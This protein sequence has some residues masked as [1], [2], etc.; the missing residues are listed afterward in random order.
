MIYNNISIK[1][2]RRCRNNSINIIIIV[3]VNFLN[4]RFFFQRIINRS[5]KKFREY[6]IIIREIILLINYFVNINYINK[7]FKIFIN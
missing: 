1:N 2:L 3:K 6:T 4:Y 7:R 5:L